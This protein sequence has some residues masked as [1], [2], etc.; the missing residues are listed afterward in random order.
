L[1]IK[2][3][4]FAKEDSYGPECSR[5]V[6]DELLPSLEALET[7]SSAIVQFLK[8][9][10][11]A[12]DEQLAPYLEQ[13]RNASTIRWRAV[14]LRMNRL[15]SAAFKAAEESAGKG[16]QQPTQR[17]AETVGES[18]ETASG[19]ELK[20]DIG[21]RPEK[22]VADNQKDEASTGDDGKKKATPGEDTGKHAA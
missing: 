7:Q 4:E 12:T 14:R 3:G 1:C 22:G 16:A 6:L 2:R 21:D 19:K 11:I 18:K 15:L 17:R 20:K 13:A 8:D 10:G 5:T 9:K